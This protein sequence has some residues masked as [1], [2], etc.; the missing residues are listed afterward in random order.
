MCHEFISTNK[1]NYHDANY[2]AFVDGQTVRWEDMCNSNQNHIYYDM[3]KEYSKNNAWWGVLWLEVEACQIARVHQ[4]L[5]G[6][7]RN[8][9]EIWEHDF[10]KGN[11]EH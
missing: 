5:R 11:D 8:E 6:K 3:W 2:V 4:F 7:E 9:Q 1:V 10:N